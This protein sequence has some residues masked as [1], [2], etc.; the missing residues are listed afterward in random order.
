MFNLAGCLKEERNI[1]DAIG[2]YLESIKIKPNQPI[3]LRTLAQLYEQTHDLEKAR[4]YAE[5]VL[6]KSANDIESHSLLASIDAR[7]KNLETQ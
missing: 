7:E 1:P 5:A 6:E 4:F 3:A 2:V